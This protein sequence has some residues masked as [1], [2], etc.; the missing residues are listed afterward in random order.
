M[1]KKNTLTTVND[2]YKVTVVVTINILIAF[3][4]DTI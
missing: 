1:C 4:K 2:L 3:I